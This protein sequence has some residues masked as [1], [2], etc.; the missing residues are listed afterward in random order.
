MTDPIK[1]EEVTRIGSAFTVPNDIIKAVNH[2]IVVN[3]DGRVA[4]IS[5]RQLKAKLHDMESEVDTSCLPVNRIAAL[6]RGQGWDVSYDDLIKDRIPESR[7]SNVFELTFSKI[8]KR[9][10][11]K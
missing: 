10:S 4:K 1:P 6:Y 9:R 2:F 11:E 5:S 8:T 3:W 7:E